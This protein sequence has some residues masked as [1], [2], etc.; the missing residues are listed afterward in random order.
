MQIKPRAPL[1][2][3]TRPHQ[4]KSRS[5]V[6]SP[7]PDPR[8]NVGAWFIPGSLT[9]PGERAAGEVKKEVGLEVS[10]QGL[11]D[12]V[13]VIVKDGEDLKYHC[14]LLCFACKLT[15][16]ELKNEE[17]LDA[18]WFSEEELKELNSVIL[19]KLLKKSRFHVLWT[20]A[21]LVTVNYYV[22]YLN[23]WLG[24]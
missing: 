5:H 16:G 19:R 11:V 10:A 20:K 14:A 18:R 22:L 1:V 15:E 4:D 17:I 2:F 12:V 13:D 24:C 23:I 6:P 21:I 9:E 3:F 8:L 7:I